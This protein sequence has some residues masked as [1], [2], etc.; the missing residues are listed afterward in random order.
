LKKSSSDFPTAEKIKLSLPP[1]RALRTVF[2]MH[3]I[4]F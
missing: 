2:I 1:L 4:N 3:N